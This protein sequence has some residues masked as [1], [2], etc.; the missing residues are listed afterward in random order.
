MT[1][2]MTT[3]Q[4]DNRYEKLSEWLRYANRTGDKEKALACQA[5]L[6]CIEA[7]ER[8]DI[9]ELDPTWGDHSPPES[10][11]S[12][13][14]CYPAHGGHPAYCARLASYEFTQT[15]AF[16]DYALDLDLQS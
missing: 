6:A 16:F 4:I 5:E 8:P 2:N 14:Y 11:H 15:D 3:K 10:C 9:S 1:T 7:E 12:P 13:E